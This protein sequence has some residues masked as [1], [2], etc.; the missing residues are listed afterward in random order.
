MDPE[1]QKILA[2]K[3]PILFK[4]LG[5][6]PRETCMSWGICVGNGWYNI[7]DDL[8]SKLEPHRVVAGQVKEK[9]GGLRFY[10]EATSSDKW[11]EIQQSIQDAE[12]KSYNTCEICGKSGKLRR[13]SWL[14]TLCDEC[15]NKGLQ[16]DD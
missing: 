16:N 7:L 15:Q 13:G 3:Y 4:K 14:K 12:A 2:N 1:K 8:C 10:L 11:D 6:D 9:F 5:G